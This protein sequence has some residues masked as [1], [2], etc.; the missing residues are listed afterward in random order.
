MTVESWWGKFTA[1]KKLRFGEFRGNGMKSLLLVAIAG[2]VCWSDPAWAEM[3]RYKDANGTIRF[4]D[5]LAD[6]TEKQ[7]AGLPVYENTS[8]PATPSATE[9]SSG[10]GTASGQNLRTQE[11]PESGDSAADSPQ[12]E[13]ILNDPSQI[14]QFLKIKLALDEE[15]AQLMKETLAL[16]EEAKTLS[17]N[18]AVKAYNEKAIALNARLDAYEK[19]RV[20][21]QKQAEIF[22]AGLK[23]RL[24]PPPQSPQPTSP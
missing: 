20:A 13:N 22:D 7:R 14:D 19:R 6:V 1:K 5:N 9:Q 17:G 4:T 3:Y 12:S 24:A 10:R 8:P 15:N 16:S 21:F 23:K 2:I 11:K 18:A